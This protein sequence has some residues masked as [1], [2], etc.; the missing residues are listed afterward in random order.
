MTD[1]TLSPAQAQFLDAACRTNFDVFAERAFR[2][3]EPGTKYEWN[4]HLGCIGEFL[5][6][7]QRGEIS[8]LIINLPPRCLKSYL[9]SK[10]FPAWILGN[11][12]TQKFISTSYGFEIAEANAR[13]CRRIM[14]DEWY[15]S[16]FPK[17]VIG[18]LDRAAHFETTKA[19]QYYAAT[20]FSP[21]TGIGCDWV[22]IDDPIKP[23]E[24]SSEAVRNSVNENVRATLFTRLNDKRTGKILVIM[25]R[26]HEDDLTGN[27]LQDGG[28]TLL[29]LPAE[30]THPI[31]IKLGNK[32]WNMKA[33]ELLFE[34]RMNRQILDQ[35]MLDMT[36]Y[37]YCTPGESP[38][39]MGDLSTKSIREIKTGD[40]IMGFTNGH[41]NLGAK[42]ERR[43]LKP[44]TVVRVTCRMAPVVRMTLDSGL[45]MRCT[46]DHKWF[47][48]RC[49]RSRNEKHRKIYAPAKI[50]SPL[51]RVCNPFLPVLK[52]EEDVHLAGWLAGFFDGK[53]SAVINKANGGCMVSFSQGTGRNLPLCDKLE[54][55]L[56]HF[57]FSFAYDSRIRGDRKYNREACHLQRWYYL[58]GNSLENLRKMLHLVRVGKWR[59]RL[60]Q[61]AYISRFVRGEE[62]V[63]SIEP[64][65]VE[66]VYGLTT[67]TGNYIVWGLASSNSGQMLQSPVPVGGGEFKDSWINYYQSGG[68]KP[69]TMNVVI[70]VD[71]A[72]GEELNRKK[73]KTSDWTAM[74]VVGLAPDNNYYLLDIVRD[75]L[76]PTERVDTLFMLHRKWND[77][78]GKPPKV[79][80]EKYGMMTDTHYIKDKMGQEG[81][82]FSL[83]ELGGRMAKEERIRRLIPDMQTG[84]WWF[85]ANLMYTDGEGRTFDLVKELIYSEMPSFPRARHDDMIDAL[86]RIYEEDLMLSF[87]RLK[88]TENQRMI[89]QAFVPQQESWADF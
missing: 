86:S 82:R 26:S 3:I 60:M 73:K 29:K 13:A 32:E 18:V 31:N 10:A 37:H 81:Y 66:P 24:A 50:G 25:Q 89:A 45:T 23:M 65:G 39:L 33:G 41:W 5:M 38:V 46:S 22:L 63:L 44:T 17:A 40:K 74:M 16:C 61:G 83:I 67:E 8:R 21:I 77:L 59:D 87:P 71:P 43:R 53:G 20:A 80:Y 6:A 56:K 35:A 84:R 49:N 30:A 27:L 62:R 47:T 52:T 79:G 85:P 15:R 70:L 4:W 9:V 76:N 64:D 34:Q 14:G 72:G 42:I 69:Q 88:Q 28:Y 19:G 58:K 55:T 57:G 7:M 48:G 54:A 75:R 36:S 11:D 78:G 1:A 51:S 68:V 12:P 2:I